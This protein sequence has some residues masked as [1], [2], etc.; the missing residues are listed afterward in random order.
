[1]NLKHK[2][3]HVPIIPQGRPGL[4][5]LH[6]VGRDVTRLQGDVAISP[7]MLSCNKPRNRRAADVVAPGQFSE[8]VALRAPPDGLLLLFRCEGRGSA[9][10]LSLRLGARAA[11]GGAGADKIALHIGQASENRQHQPPGAGAGVGPRFRQGSE[12]R[13]GVHD[14]LDDAEEVKGAARKPVDPRCGHLL[15]VDV[16]AVAP[17]LAKLLK[18]AVEGLPVGADAG[19]PDEPFFGVCFDYNLRQ[20]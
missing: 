19:V 3:A 14:A 11:F 4:R 12:L 1:M 5:N 9:H 10:G 6:L 2:A 18:L 16:P 8:R 17:R 13:L 20:L 7:I 15:F